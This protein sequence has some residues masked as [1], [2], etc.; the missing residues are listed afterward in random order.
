MDLLRRQS[1][2]HRTRRGG[3]RTRKWYY[4]YIF[5]IVSL[6]CPTW[7][8]IMFFRHALSVKQLF[9][10][11]LV[12]SFM[13]PTRG[14]HTQLKCKLCASVANKKEKSDEGQKKNEKYDTRRISHSPHKV[15]HRAHGF[16]QNQ[17]RNG[18]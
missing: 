16:R 11:S 6:R 13:V 7:F 2:R 4:Y 14:T 17:L 9:I 1:C 3:V 18:K 15:T 5:L 8:F 10:F 12:H